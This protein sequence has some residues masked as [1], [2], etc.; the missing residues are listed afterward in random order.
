MKRFISALVLGS[1]TVFLVLGAPKSIGAIAASLVVLLSA[2]EMAGLLGSGDCAPQRKWLFSA[3]LLV[4]GGGILLGVNGICAGFAAGAVLIMAGSMEGSSVKGAIRRSASGVFVLFLPVWCL[5]HIVLFFST[6]EMRIAL[7]FLLVCIWV[8]DSAAF[9]AGSAFGRRKLAP[10]VSP[11]KTV[12][13]SLAGILGAVAAALIFRSFSPLD[14]SLSF[15]VLSGLLL[16]AAGQAGDLAESMIKRD[17]GVKDSG[18]IIPGHGGVL[19]RVD[20]ML[21][22]VPLFYYAL[23]WFLGSQV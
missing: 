23:T 12:V 3:S 22:T 6:R 5:A 19:D 1:A 17:A 8:S 15:V 9:Y 13:G 4:L 16:S 7:L 21:F 2:S 14:W 18:K 10:A 11:N 20:A